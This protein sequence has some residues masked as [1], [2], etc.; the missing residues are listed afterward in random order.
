MP[1]CVTLFPAPPGWQG[2]PWVAHLTGSSS[3]GSLAPAPRADRCALLSSICSLAGLATELPKPRRL[4]FQGIPLLSQESFCAVNNRS[5]WISGQDLFVQDLSQEWAP[6][7]FLGQGQEAR[8][9]WLC[10]LK[11]LLGKGIRRLPLI[12]PLSSCQGPGLPPSITPARKV[13]TGLCFLLCFVL[14]RRANRISMETGAAFVLACALGRSM[15]VCMWGSWLAAS[16]S[17]WDQSGADRR[18]WEQGNLVGLSALACLRR[19][20]DGSQTHCFCQAARG[21]RCG[22]GFLLGGG[23]SRTR[24]SPCPR[25]RLLFRDLR[26]F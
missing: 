6:G 8:C 9:P 25:H 24:P 23:W 18:P 16:S 26:G 1:W 4:P 7:E 22:G 2:M 5:L 21:M 20:G 12:L 14:L 3:P 11:G 17:L 19:L 15:G 10:W 13:V